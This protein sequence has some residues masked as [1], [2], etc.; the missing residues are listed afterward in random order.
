MKWLDRI[1]R[2]VELPSNRRLERCRFAIDFEVQWKEDRR[3]D[4]LRLLRR[5]ASRNACVQPCSTY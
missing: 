5:A 1:D 2:K 3:D 4:V